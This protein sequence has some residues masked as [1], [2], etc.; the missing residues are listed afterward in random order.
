MSEYRI[1][2]SESCIAAST[3]IGDRG[4]NAADLR[5]FLQASR[6]PWHPRSTMNRDAQM[7]TSEF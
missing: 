7:Q 6:D 4:L 2:N 1:Q 3:F 5:G